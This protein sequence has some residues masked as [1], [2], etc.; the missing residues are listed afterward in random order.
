[1]KQFDWGHDHYALA[2]ECLG[3]DDLIEFYAT[4]IKPVIL[5]NGADELG[6]G[7]NGYELQ[8]L[9][10]AIKPDYCI[11]P[12]VLE[13]AQLTRERGLEFLSQAHNLEHQPK[14]MAVIQGTSVAEWM[15]EL[16][17]WLG[18]GVDL[19]GIPYDINF[20]IPD[21]EKF[22]TK[23]RQWA[24]RRAW[25]LENICTMYLNRW[26]DKQIHLLGVND[27]CEFQMIREYVDNT[28][29]SKIRSNDTTAPYAAA[30]HDKFFSI[31]DGI[32]TSHEKD[33]PALNFHNDDIDKNNLVWNMCLYFYAT[34][35][36]DW[37]IWPEEA[38][39]MM[40][41]LAAFYEIDFE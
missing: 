8:S 41:T 5:D 40:E 19:I 9:I 39:T 25:L 38:R 10:E 31:E 14:W 26:G 17:F 34:N 32:I 6:E 2:H 28:I 1:M 21:E 30:A 16:H 18:E 7:M 15:Q 12:D 27:V 24:F 29:Y 36:H 13:N 20:E 37:A 23:S 35:P 33:W 4:S 3:N 22:K 11:L